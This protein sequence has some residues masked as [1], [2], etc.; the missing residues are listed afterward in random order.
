M[1]GFVRIVPNMVHCEIP[2]M[3]LVDTR[4]EFAV[5]KVSD[6]RIVVSGKALGLQEDLI[7]DFDT[8]KGPWRSF[9]D[10]QFVRTEPNSIHYLDKPLI[11]AIET[12]LAEH[13]PA[14]KSRKPLKQFTIHVHAGIIHHLAKLQRPLLIGSRKAGT[15][16]VSI[17]GRS[18][19]DNGNADDLTGLKELVGPKRPRGVATHVWL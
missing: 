7:T 16:M 4:R 13:H 9:D 12:A 15:L 19:A 2:V 3:L 10:T 11:P 17:P 6:L 1:N 5:S 14:T 8:P 18:T